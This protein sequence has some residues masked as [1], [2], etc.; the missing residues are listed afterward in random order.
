MLLEEIFLALRK[1]RPHQADD[2]RE[3]GL[4]HLH[5][6][7]EPLNHDDRIAVTSGTVCIEQYE[8]LP[9]PSGELYLGS[10]SPRVLPA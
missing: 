1:G 9:K 10:P 5:A 2:A 8:R 6:I 4:M 3:S 7:K